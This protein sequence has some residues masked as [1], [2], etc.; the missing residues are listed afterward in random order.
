V[1][2]AVK[3]SGAELK[4][5]QQLLLADLMA[6]FEPRQLQARVVIR[7]ARIGLADSNSFRLG[8]HVLLH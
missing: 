2:T 7:Q 5:Y 4:R 1:T 8:H 3:S 6:G